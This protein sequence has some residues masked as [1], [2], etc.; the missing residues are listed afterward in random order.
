[1]NPFEIKIKEEDKIQLLINQIEELEKA[2]RNKKKEEEQLK[3][4][5]QSLVDEVEKRKL[6]KFS[7]TTPSKTK[8]TYVGSTEPKEVVEKYFCKELFKQDYPDLYEKY[9]RDITELKGGRKSY[10]RV[11]IPKED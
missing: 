8:L 1:M 3:E 9:C 11:T 2:L 7:W 4:F 6:L 5:K 10:I